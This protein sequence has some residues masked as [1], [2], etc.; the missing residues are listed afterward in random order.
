MDLDPQI[1][2]TLLVKDTFVTL[3]GLEPANEYCVEVAAKTIAG[4][5]NYTKFTLPCEL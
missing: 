4:Y 2:Q 5:G 3:T 1:S